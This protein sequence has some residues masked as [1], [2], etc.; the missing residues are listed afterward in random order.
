MVPVTIIPNETTIMC[1][2]KCL[3]VFIASSRHTAEKPTAAVATSVVAVTI[4]L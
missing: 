2:A 3:I 1:R 4:P